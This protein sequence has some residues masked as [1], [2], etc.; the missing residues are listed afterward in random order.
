M[1]IKSLRKDR[2]AKTYTIHHPIHGLQSLAFPPKSSGSSSEGA[3]LK[4]ELAGRVY[5]PIMALSRS[6][7]PFGQLD[8]ALIERQV[9]ADRVLPTLVGASEEGEPGLEELVDLAQS[10]SFGGRALDCHDY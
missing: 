5:G 8:E 3:L 9:V 2:S 10:E 1:E 4:H 6:S 7:Q